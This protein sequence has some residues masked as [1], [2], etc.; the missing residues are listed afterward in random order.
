MEGEEWME[1]RARVRGRAMPGSMSPQHGRPRGGRFV[2]ARFLLERIR[3]S[4]VGKLRKMEER[5][6]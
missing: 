1:E 4:A 6:Y 3:V 2:V 5:T